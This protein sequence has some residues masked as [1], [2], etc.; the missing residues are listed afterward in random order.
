M[1]MAQAQFGQLPRPGIQGRHRP[2]ERAGHVSGINC[3]CN[4]F[5]VATH[6]E[7]VRD[8]ENHGIGMTVQVE[9][10]H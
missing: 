9:T 8:S 4:P 3:P 10:M 2:G 5:E 7:Y 6:V 1:H